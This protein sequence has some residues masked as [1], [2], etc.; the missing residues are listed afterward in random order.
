MVNV[1]FILFFVS[2]MMVLLNGLIFCCWK[3]Y[4]QYEEEKKRSLKE[5]NDYYSYDE[6]FISYNK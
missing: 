2:P 4:K 1:S 6:K 5:I 3:A